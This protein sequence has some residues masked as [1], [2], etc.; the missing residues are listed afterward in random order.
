M[1]VSACKA[2]HQSV[3]CVLRLIGS[4]FKLLKTLRTSSKSSQSFSSLRYNIIRNIKGWGGGGEGRG[5]VDVCKFTTLTRY[6]QV[7]PTQCQQT[8]ENSRRCTNYMYTCI[9]VALEGFWSACTLTCTKYHTNN[10]YCS[11]NLQSRLLIRLVGHL[12]CQ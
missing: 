8:T 7:V 10:M 12:A 4:I 2:R 3:P 5:S 11:F 6:L 1:V 9:R